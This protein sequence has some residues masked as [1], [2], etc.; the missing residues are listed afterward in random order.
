MRMKQKAV[1][2]TNSTAKGNQRGLRGPGDYND[3]DNNNLSVKTLT[4]KQN[5]VVRLVVALSGG[6]PFSLC[7]LS[8]P[9]QTA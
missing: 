1:A 7:S 6:Y 2:G 8:L 9:S 3:N 5:Q 4:L